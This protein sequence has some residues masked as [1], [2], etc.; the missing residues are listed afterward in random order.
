MAKRKR[1][2]YQPIT[3]RDWFLYHLCNDKDFIEIRKQWQLEINDIDQEPGQEARRRAEIEEITTRYIEPLHQKFGINEATARKG[4][5]YKKHNRI[6]NGDRVP[7]AEI[8]GDRVIISIGT[9]T[10]LKDVEDLW[11]P[12]ISLLQSKLPNYNSQRETPSDEPLLAYTVYKELRTGR[13]LKNIHDAYL[14]GTL[15]RKIPE[16]D[17]WLEV[18]DFRKYYKEVVK[19]YVDRP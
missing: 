6:L 5:L 4:L 15:H 19:G 3:A 16:G 8:R 13:T 1:N 17:K 2:V 18:S 10:A 7:V 14:G 12:W 11:T 9:N